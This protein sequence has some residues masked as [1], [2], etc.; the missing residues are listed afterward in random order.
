[1]GRARLA[2]AIGALWGAWLARPSQ[3]LEE[4]PGGPHAAVQAMD[5]R[6]RHDALAGI[7]RV[8]AGWMQ[9]GNGEAPDAPDCIRE[10]PAA[11]RSMDPP[12]QSSS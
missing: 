9:W 11:K 2:L 7:G 5:V 4:A 1:M 10:K 8:Q 12:R 6:V 3:R